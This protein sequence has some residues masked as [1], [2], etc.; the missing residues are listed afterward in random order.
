MPA[1]TTTASGDWNTSGTWV[2]GNIPGNGDTAT[3][4]HAV[5]VSTAVTVGTSPGAASGTPAIRCNAALTISSTGNLTVRGDIEL[6]NVALTINS[7]IL[8]FDASQAASPSTAR[9]TCKIGTNTSD[10]NA[11]LVTTGTISTRAIIRS[12]SGGANGRFTDNG[13]DNTG[14]VDV[15]HCEF[16]R[17]GDS[18]NHAFTFIISSSHIFRIKNSVFDACGNIG[19]SSGIGA[20]EGGA[21]IHLDGVTMKNTVAS[22]SVGLTGVTRSG[23]GVRTV[24]NCVFDKQA[25]FYGVGGYTITNNVFKDTWDATGAAWTTFSGNLLAL[26]ED[27]TQGVVGFGNISD[28]YFLRVANPSNQ[29]ML[30][31]GTEDMAI[32]VSGCIFDAPDMTNG[33]GDNILFN[34]PATARTFNVNHNIVLD[35]ESGTD[36]GTLVSL[37]GGANVTV[38]ITHNTYNG[39]QGIYVAEGY[40]G[41]SGMISLCA[42]NLSWS[43]TASSSYIIKSDPGPATNLVTSANVHHNG[44]R[45]P[46]STDGY[47]DDLSFS[48]GTPGASDVNGNPNF[49]DIDRNIKKWDNSLG[50]ANTVANALTELSKRNDSAGYNSSYSISNLITYVKAGFAPTNASFLA[51]SDSV[52]PSNGW[53]G[54]L[55]GGNTTNSTRTVSLSQAGSL[56]AFVRLP[57]FTVKIG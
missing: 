24:T 40:S 9:Y 41:H 54:A 5:T 32:T 20:Y 57:K 42:N 39:G 4:D 34:N 55:A 11:K 48:S 23:A 35:T 10:S 28:C 1:R 2:G 8:E 51:A 45:N 21:T 6:N 43:A 36:V 53:M 47:D 37:L 31:I 44:V 52:A 56:S 16:L 3:L 46:I 7:G 18:S 33:A 29:H 38:S 25:R 27:N 50:G 13:N 19:N 26:P 49:V 15:D 30:T 22:Y 14:Q 12:N 17:I